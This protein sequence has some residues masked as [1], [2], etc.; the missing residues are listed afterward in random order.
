MENLR[1]LGGLL[2][3]ASRK[4]IEDLEKKI[5]ESSKSGR[6]WRP[7]DLLSSKEVGLILGMH[8]KTVERLARQRK[9]P[10]LRIGWTLKFLYS[11]VLAMVAQLKE[12]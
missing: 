7:I 5:A 9:L 12:G 4:R 10:C 3:G 11:D 2:A 8:H 1:G 6:Q